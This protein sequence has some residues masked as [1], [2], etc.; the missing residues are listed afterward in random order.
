MAQ[1]FPSTAIWFPFCMIKPQP[2]FLSDRFYSLWHPFLASTYSTKTE[3]PITTKFANQSKT[4][5][6][7]LQM[8]YNFLPVLPYFPNTRV[9]GCK[10]DLVLERSVVILDHH[11]ITVGEHKVP[12]YIYQDSALKL[13]WFVRRRLLGVFTIYGHGDHLGH[14]CRT[15]WTNR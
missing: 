5:I 2:L 7:Y 3:N 15:V 14:W 12:E 4:V 1:S 8:L 6:A 11:L 10:V 9:C 13:S